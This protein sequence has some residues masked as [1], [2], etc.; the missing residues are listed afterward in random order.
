MAPSNV[1]K[2]VPDGGDSQKKGKRR[3]KVRGLYYPLG[4]GGKGGGEG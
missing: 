4:K 2:W 3:G 1:L